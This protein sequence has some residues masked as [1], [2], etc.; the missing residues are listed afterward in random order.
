MV[1]GHQPG[2][3]LNAR[4]EAKNRDFQLISRK[5]ELAGYN[6]S[7][8]GAAASTAPGGAGSAAGEDRSHSRTLGTCAVSAKAEELNW[9]NVKLRLLVT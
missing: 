8:A 1:S 9:E 2:K 3:H 7:L 6:N 4:D 5:G